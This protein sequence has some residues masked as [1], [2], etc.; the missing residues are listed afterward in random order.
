MKKSSEEGNCHMSI[1]KNEATCLLQTIYIVPAVYELVRTMP[2]DVFDPVM[3]YEESVIF[4]AL[5][6]L[7]GDDSSIKVSP[8]LLEAKT[9]D[10]CQRSDAELSPDDQ[11]ILGEILD[12]VTSPDAQPLDDALVKKY[13][14]RI[15]TINT[16]ES[17]RES[18]S[19]ITERETTEN[20][21]P[22]FA[23]TVQKA[24]AS[25][26]LL[27]EEAIDGVVVR[28][29]EA[30]ENML[31]TSHSWATGVDFF[32]DLTEGGV[33]TRK[34]WG[35]LAPT[36]GGKTTI[37]I[38]LLMSWVRQG[39]NHQALY[40]SYEQPIEGDITERI[41]S[42]TID[43]PR[44][45]FR[46]KA[47]SDWDHDLQLLVK[48]RSELFS[49]RVVC[50]DYSGNNAAGSDGI[51][52]I[53]RTLEKQGI[54]KRLDDPT[55]DPAKEPP[56]FVLIDW[57]LPMVQR[58]MNKYS[59]GMLAVGNE[60]RAVGAS[61]MDEIK[62]FKNTYNVMVLITHQLASAVADASPTKAASHTDSAE[63]KG[64]ANLLDD[65]FTIGPRSKQDLCIMKA[66]KARASGRNEVVLKLAGK[67]ARFED[68][69][70]EYAVV[71]G[72]FV[73]LDGDVQSDEQSSSEGLAARVVGNI[74]AT[75]VSPQ[76]AQF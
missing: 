25:D 13:C 69:S 34:L 8:Q 24:L 40:A 72:K 66:S 60:L 28:P 27:D 18:L 47:Y 49:N 57:L 73:P 74:R 26:M 23:S 22:V 4:N 6:E 10:I 56:V 1:S 14:Q 45:L 11:A 17:L 15:N 29:L 41:V 61:I 43:K 76:M 30:L 31:T 39:P 5:K 35:L 53:K 50:S 52:N 38:Q 75:N 54:L 42:L 65:C 67:Y 9:F 16:V 36:G 21:L 2:G 63:W 7:K 62:T 37:S 46:D 19:V 64:F 58:Y 59:D 44:S 32:D 20:V 70:T 55:F 51:Q 12:F 33:R 71:N 68:F 3:M 48:K